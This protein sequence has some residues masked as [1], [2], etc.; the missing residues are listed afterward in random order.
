MKYVLIITALLFVP[1]QAQV[2]KSKLKKGCN[3]LYTE[4]VQTKLDQFKPQTTKED[5]KEYR[6]FMIATKL[7]SDLGFMLRPF[8]EI[9]TSTQRVALRTPLQ[10][11]STCR[12]VLASGVGS[13]FQSLGLTR[14][15][16]R[17]CDKTYAV[18][19]Q[20][21]LDKLKD[22]VSPTILTSYRDFMIR[23]KKFEDLAYAI[24]QFEKKT[25]RTLMG[26]LRL[27][28]REYETCRDSLIRL[29]MSPP[30]LPR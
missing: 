29:S 14:D 11:Y 4:N 22:H 13:G 21:T 18:Q 15:Q 10:R 27:P 12:T 8:E 28:V 6:S 25:N 1:V 17:P 9:L 7:H 23:L 24:R 5:L 30:G 2:T 26:R 20:Q 19:M 3:A 16:L